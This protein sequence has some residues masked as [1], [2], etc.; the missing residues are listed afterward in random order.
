MQKW[1]RLDAGPVPGSG[2]TMELY[3]GGEELAIRVDGRE[4]MS[5][6][7]H[8]SE[9][10]LAD[11]AFDR[12]GPRPGLRVLIGGL[13]MGFTLAAALRRAAADTEVVVAEL[14]PTIVAWNRGPLGPLADHPLRDPRASVFEGDVRAPIAARPGAWDAILLDVDNG[15]HGLT[16]EDNDWLYGW[17]GLKA[18]YAA[19]RPG[20]VLGVW[21][22]A[23]DDRFTRRLI[24]AGFDAAPIPVRARGKRG[25][26]R[27][28]VWI[29][30]RGAARG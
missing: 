12:L 9:D 27:H 17:H 2:G 25:G 15:P 22:A 5:S 23:P 10:A 11:L 29:A 24:R 4:L 30:V 3:R 16:H 26:Q 20:G 18:A 19:L 28:I 7:M 1:A 8:G 14:V 13:G 21:S 6:R